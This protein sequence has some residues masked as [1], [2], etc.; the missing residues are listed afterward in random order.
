MFLELTAKTV[1]QKW[2]INIKSIAFFYPYN[3][4]TRICFIGDDTPLDVKEDYETVKRTINKAR[5]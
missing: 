1:N 2:A 4:G 5:L 3:N